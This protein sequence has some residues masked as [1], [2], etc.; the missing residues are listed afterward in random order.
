MEAVAEGRGRDREFLCSLALAARRIKLKKVNRELNPLLS[1][2]V[3]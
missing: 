1:Q 3:R 2:R